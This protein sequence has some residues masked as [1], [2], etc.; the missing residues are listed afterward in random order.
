[1]AKY[2]GVLTA[3]GDSP[4]LNAALRGMG[5][6]AIGLYG[7]QIVG[8][9]EGFRGLMQNRT[10]ALD[11]AALSGI[12]TKGGTILGTSRDKPHAM[13]VGGK[14]LDVSHVFQKNSI[15]I[16][17]F[18]QKMLSF[19]LE[20]LNLSFEFQGFFL[21]T[22]QSCGKS[23]EFLDSCF[24]Q[25]VFLLIFLQFLDL[26]FQAFLQHLMFICHTSA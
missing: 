22:L 4:G 18:K 16:R 21:V 20:M 8:F 12:L 1:M 19:S 2:V 11:E 6:S 25:P 23:N 24:Q 14:V 15:E 3:G 5:K 7:M 26:N 17:V 13:P 10:V 9:R